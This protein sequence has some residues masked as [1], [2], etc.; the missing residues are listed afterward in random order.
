MANSPESAFASFTSKVIV[1]PPLFTKCVYFA[2]MIFLAFLAGCVE[3]EPIAFMRKNIKNHNELSDVLHDVQDRESA[4]TALDIVDLKGA[5][6]VATL[7]ESTNILL[8][9]KY[10]RLPK[11]T[12]DKLLQ[13]LDAATQRLLAELERIDR[14]RGLPTRFWNNLYPKKFEIGIISL[15]TIRAS[16]QYEIDEGIYTATC[17]ARD[18]LAL[19]GYDKVA[20]LRLS[21][22]PR[23]Y[24]DEADVKIKEAADGAALCKFLE[25][26]KNTIIVGPVEDFAA[27][28][29]KLD[30]GAIVCQDDSRRYLEIQA[31]RMKLGARASTAKAERELVQAELLKQ[32]LEREKER[33]ER[34]K[35]RQ[36]ELDERMAERRKPDPNDPDYFD[37]LADNL[38]GDDH[39]RRKEAIDALLKHSP[40]EVESSETRKKIARGFKEIALDDDRHFE[41]GKAIRGMARW[42]GKFCV[43]FL[44]E[45]LD[46]RRSFAIKDDL[47]KVLGDLQDERAAAPVAARLADRSDRDKAKACLK[48]MGPVAEDAV[49]AVAPSPNA[50]VC[51]AAI[52]ILSEIGAQ[53]SV[54]FLR[55]SISK[56]RNPV[57]KDAIKMAIKIILDR[58]N[59]AEAQP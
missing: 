29:R 8:R 26:D 21:E 33:Q 5:Q 23:E 10:T 7:R 47:F 17:E 11:R 46:E 12:T 39:F 43:P 14:L 54:V 45:L 15:D 58:E 32:Q 13:E 31:D 35:R 40:S 49:I 38:L 48:R 51:L 2:P 53:K 20:M 28:A 4:E 1:V 37:K 41:R 59:K 27:F 55:S 9:N 44:L 18:L 52:E 24:A 3:P 25:F 19:H 50:D 36:Q 42:G 22:L 6:L 56:T 16:G 57:V 34:E 30:I